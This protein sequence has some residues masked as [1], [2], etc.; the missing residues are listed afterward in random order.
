MLSLTLVVVI[1]AAGWFMGVLLGWKARGADP[2]TGLARYYEGYRQ[3]FR[4]A[5][6]GLN[7]EPLP[8]RR[9]YLSDGGDEQP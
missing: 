7:P 6:R 8:Q 1:F 5:M 3:G 9:T 2:E 4:K